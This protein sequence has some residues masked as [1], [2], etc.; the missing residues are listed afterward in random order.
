MKKI[1][2]MAFAFTFLCVFLTACVSDAGYNKDLADMTYGFEYGYVALP[3]GECVKGKV[4]TW[5]DF[6]DGDMLQVKIEGK[7]YL[8]HSSNV[9]LVHKEK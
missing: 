3:S 8:T 6:E 5:T 1:A 7:T 9:V 2:S 4:E